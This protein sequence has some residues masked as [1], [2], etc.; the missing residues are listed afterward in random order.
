MTSH[1]SYF[2]TPFLLPVFATNR[3]EQRQQQCLEPIAS[4]LTPKA[5]LLANS[6]DGELSPHINKVKVLSVYADSELM[7]LQQDIHSK[8]TQRNALTYQL[9]RLSK[10]EVEMVNNA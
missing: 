2:T 1:K 9:Y 8:V 6:T 3:A 7:K 10:T 5:Q 4:R